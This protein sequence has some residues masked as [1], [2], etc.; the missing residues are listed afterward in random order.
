MIL[1]S[2]FY[3]LWRIKGLEPSIALRTSQ[4]WLR[5]AELDEIIR[6]CSTFISDLDFL[7]ELRRTLKLVGCSSPYHWAAFSYTGI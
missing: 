5:D 1:L 4:Q 7:K 6:H 2:R 3:T